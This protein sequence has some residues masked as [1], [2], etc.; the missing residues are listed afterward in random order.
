MQN[1]LIINFTLTLELIAWDAEIQWDNKYI[2]DRL[3]TMYKSI[4]QNRWLWT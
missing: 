2:A 3:E 4:L 1:K